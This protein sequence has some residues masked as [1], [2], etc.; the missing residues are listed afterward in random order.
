[1]VYT[2][3]SGS[4]RQFFAH[5]QRIKDWMYGCRFM[6]DSRLTVSRPGIEVKWF[7]REDAEH[8]GVLLN[9][10]NEFAVAGATVTLHSPLFKEAPLAL[11]YL[12]DEEE[13]IMMACAKS[14]DGLT[15]SLPPAKASSILI[16]VRIPQQEMIR[17][18]LVWPQTAGADKL[19]LTIAN[20]GKRPQTLALAYNLPPGITLK[21][22][23]ATVRI[24]AFEV[25]RLELPVAGIATLSGLAEVTVA[26]KAGAVATTCRTLLRPVLYNGDFETDSAGKGT[27]DAWRTLGCGW[28]TQLIQNLTLPFDLNQAD[29]VLDPQEPADGKYSLRL[30]G[31]VPVPNYWTGERE[32]MWA[33]ELREERLKLADKTDWLFN[34]GQVLT[35]KP[36]TRYEVAFKF[37][38]AADDAVIEMAS[39][40]YGNDVASPEFFPTQKV[41]AAKGNRGW[42]NHTFS[43]TTP[44]D[45]AES[46]L[47]FRNNSNPPVWI[48]AVK[49]MAKDKL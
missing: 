33:K 16:P 34:T 31:K 2:P 22:P 24:A 26:V 15:I 19:I 37:R 8:R 29:G 12:M 3:G 9:I 7:Q 47:I 6:D 36:G 5:R 46:V 44:V 39:T 48:D 4:D 35:L 43:F 10:Q 25:K 18:H 11:A 42:Q 30:P 32:C 1:M 13:V 21:D 20:L 38:T 17:T 41:S 28:F 49:V 14:K 45:R 40:V 27:P 23:P